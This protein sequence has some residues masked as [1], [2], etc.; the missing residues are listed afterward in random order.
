MVREQIS[1]IEIVEFPLTES[2]ADYEGV[3]AFFFLFVRKRT[4]TVE[5]FIQ[6]NSQRLRESRC[7][8]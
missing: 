2:V 3:G 7:S 1:F 4:P 8:L 5:P 6:T